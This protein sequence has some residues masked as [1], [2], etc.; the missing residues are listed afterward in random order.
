MSLDVDGPRPGATSGTPVE[1]SRV[2]YADD[3]VEIGLW[4][5]TPGSFP[6]AK[7]GIGEHMLILAGD[8]T[9]T[10][11]DG[12]SIDLAPGVSFVQ[13]DGWRGRWVIRETVVKQY[14][15]WKTR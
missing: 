3:A 14:T 1:S 9:I 2:L 5:C 11:A 4:S 6:G 12:T 10:G 8:A 15:I 7:D 13:P